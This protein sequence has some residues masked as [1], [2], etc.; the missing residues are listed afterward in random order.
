MKH[1]FSLDAVEAVIS[2]RAAEIECYN[3]VEALECAETGSVDVCEI[4]ID[5]VNYFYNHENLYADP[6]I[7]LN[8]ELQ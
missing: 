1:D 6:F 4:N 5:G 3:S 8:E 2:Y 7:E